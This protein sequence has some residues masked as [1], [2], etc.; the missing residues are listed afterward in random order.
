MEREKTATEI[1]A[2]DLEHMN[3]ADAHIFV[4]S[5]HIIS[6]IALSSSQ[7]HGAVHAQ[8]LFICPTEL[9]KIS[10]WCLLH[11]SCSTPHA[12]ILSTLN[13]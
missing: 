6:N 12:F 4:Q 11:P 10:G 13:V 5:C 9:T 2:F 3:G 8:A 7:M 1:P